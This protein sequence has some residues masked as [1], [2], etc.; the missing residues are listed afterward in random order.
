M[1]IFNRTSLPKIIIY[2]SRIYRLNSSVVA[3][4][5]LTNVTKETVE[6]LECSINKHIVIVNVLSNRLRGK[7]NIHN[8]PYEPTHWIFISDSDLN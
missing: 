5:C 8:K 2:N 6:T 3:N 4:R 1:K 7:S